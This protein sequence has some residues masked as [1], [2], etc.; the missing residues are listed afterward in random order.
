MGFPTTYLES[1]KFE[2]HRYKRYGDKTFEQ[3]SEE[4]LF[5]SASENDNSIAV[6]V[7]HLA[8]NMLSRWTNF[9]MEDGEKVW[10]DRDSEFEH[11][12]QSKK[13]LLDLWEEGWQCLFDALNSITPENFDASIQIRNQ[14][15]SIPQAINRQLAHYASHVGQLLFIG[16]MIKKDDW[17]SLSIPKG[18]SKIFNKKMFGENS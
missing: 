17:V 1:A 5:W 13:E 15:H 12:P 7:N 9:L 10:R 4:E 18:Q 14:K 3:L 16:K 11:P 8:G 2:F 6:I